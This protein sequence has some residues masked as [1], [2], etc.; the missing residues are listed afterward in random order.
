MK[1]LISIIVITYNQ[2]DTISRT[3]DSILSQET[4]YPI[5]IIIGDDAS[6]DKTYSICKEFHDN[7]PDIIRLF[8]NK[9]NNGILNNYYDCILRAKG[10]YIADCAGDDFW[11]DKYK[12]QKQAEV[13]E[14]DNDI[15]LI[16]TGWK[17]YNT[18]SE[19]YSDSDP[20]GIRTPFLKPI[21][22]RGDL[23]LPILRRD[24]PIIIHLCTAMYRRDIIID[25][26]NKDISLFRNKEFTCEDIQLE[27]VM[28]A[29]GKI[30]YIPDIT[31]A[32]RQG[33]ISATSDESFEKNFNFYFGT[34]KL[35]RYLQ[36][37][38][39]VSDT[40]LFDYYNKVIA[41][42]Y[43]QL[44]YCGNREYLNS[45]K[46]FIKP[47]QFKYHWKTQ[48]YRGLIKNSFIHKLTRFICLS[49]KNL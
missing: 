14:R 9:K 17:Y 27:V 19:T 29:R 4:D 32:Y 47:I 30:A 28:A 33:H 2:Q 6:S 37:K 25:E 31:L 36:L 39:N 3:L 43:S 45:F 12:L 41:Y 46:C 40:I 38:F 11:I 21:F 24:S 49:L 23:V 44:F 10:Q 13:L 22:N 42:L 5:E 34:L 15:S 18:Y 7:Y 8:R 48:I 35:N 16:H 26:Y 1:P 20:L